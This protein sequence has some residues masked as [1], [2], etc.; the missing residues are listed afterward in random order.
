MDTRGKTNA[1]F[2]NEVHEILAW[3]E[4]SF[5]QV[6]SSLQTILTEL[7]A[8]RISRSPTKHNPEINPFAFTHDHRHLKLSFPK[9]G[10]EDPTGWLYKAAQYFEF[11][12]IS[13]E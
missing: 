4:S 10:G 3:H 8:M 2:C 6:H 7:Q 12:R 11:K 5:D 9:F 13:P 1:E